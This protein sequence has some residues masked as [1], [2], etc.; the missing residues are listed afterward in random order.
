MADGMTLIAEH[1]PLVVGANTTRA[2]IQ[3]E[4]AYWRGRQRVAVI[5]STAAEHGVTADSYLDALL[6]AEPEP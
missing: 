4:I 1:V 3:A 2:Q 5:P 6:A